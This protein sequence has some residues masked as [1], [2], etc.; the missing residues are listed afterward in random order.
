MERLAQAAAKDG[1][2]YAENRERSDVQAGAGSTV[3]IAAHAV[4]LFVFNE[5][6][7]LVAGLMEDRQVAMQSATSKAGPALQQGRPVGCLR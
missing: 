1:R 2:E 5:S 6:L 4:T 7:R 3:R